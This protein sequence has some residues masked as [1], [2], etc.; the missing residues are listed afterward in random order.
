[1]LRI[2]VR[3]G[4]GR[5]EIPTDLNGLDRVLA[6]PSCLVWVDAEGEPR[7]SLEA[8]A[9]L[10]QLHPITL[11][12]LINR[13]QRPKIEEFDEYVFLVVHAL[14][15]IHGDELDTEEIDV[16][17]TK[18]A[19][20]T[21]H[22]RPLEHLYRVF[23]RSAKDSRILQHGPDFLVYLLS[24]ALVDAYFPVLEALEDEI[25]ALEDA[26]VQAPAR[27]RMRRI[28]E[29]KRVLVQLR[30]VVSPQ[31]EVYNALSRRDYP[32]IEA[33]TAVYFRD[34]HDHLV[35]AFEMIDS[36]RD[37]AA[38]TLEAYLAATSNRLGQVMKQLTV[39][40]TVFMPLTFLTGFFGMNFATI[41]FHSVWLLV[42]ALALMGAL[43]IVMIVMFLR[44][45]W[46]TDSRRITSWTRLRVWF[47]RRH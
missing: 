17:L 6:D 14:R 4:D 29:V 37:L 46:L 1:M 40:A 34:I 42:A 8:L 13:N 44:S 33:R 22:G 23:D 15:S 38:N 31:R 39:I 27:A 26:V 11:D 47:F 41:P 35:R 18:S 12:D 24:D 9:A 36:Y 2:L 20:L 28:F 21:T 10:F 16:A 43:P 32:Y 30:K 19:L 25:D 45:G 3:H 7:E 5:I